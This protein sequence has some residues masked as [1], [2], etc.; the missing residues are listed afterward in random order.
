V[1]VNNYGASDVAMP[2]GGHKQSGF[3]RE[4]GRHVIDLFTQIKSVYVKL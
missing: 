3:G 1:W 2:F 4:G